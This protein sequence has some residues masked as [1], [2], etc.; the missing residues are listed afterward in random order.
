VIAIPAVDLRAGACVQLVGGA[1]DAE[2]VR[3]PDPVGAARRWAEL[4][5]SRLHVVDLDA[6][7]GVGSNAT[8]IDEILDATP[9][10]TQVGGGVRDDD[11]VAALLRAG[12]TSVIVGTRAVEEPEWLGAIARRHVGRIVVAIDV[13]ERHVVV[14]GWARTLPLDV[15]HA[16]RA[17]DSLPLGGVLVTAVH[18]EGQMRGPDADLIED[19]VRASP[20]PVI[21]AGGV[22]TMSDLRRLADCGVAG[23]VIGM[24]LY[25]G[26]LDASAV[27]D[28]FGRGS[29]D[30]C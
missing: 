5:F 13:R 25:T 26:T 19:V 18:R 11:H 27:A 21:A 22:G 1:P 16:M 20:V 23:T 9:A 7:L 8:L 12:A 24:A 29:A 3:L 2:R 15:S 4:G 17:L 14:R 30:G 6:A 28:E 10:V